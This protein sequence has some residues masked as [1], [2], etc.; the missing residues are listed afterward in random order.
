MIA[1]APAFGVKTIANGKSATAASV[2]RQTMCRV[3]A[4][5]RRSIHTNANPNAAV[6]ADFNDQSIMKVKN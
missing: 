3:A 4:D 1:G 5:R 6:A 2:I